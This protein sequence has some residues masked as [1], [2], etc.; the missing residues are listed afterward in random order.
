MDKEILD[1]ITLRLG[2]ITGFLFLAIIIPL[3]I[4]WRKEALN[5]IKS[6]LED[7]IILYKI[8]FPFSVDYVFPFCVGGFF[9]SFILPFWVFNNV[10]NVGIVDKVSLFYFI[11]AELL[12]FFLI[13][14][15]SSWAEVITNKKIRR[16]WN[17]KILNKI[18]KPMD[19]P[20]EEIR[21][22]DLQKFLFLKSISI[23]TKNNLLYTLGG[24]KDMDKIK[25]YLDNLVR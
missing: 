18:G 12:L 25:I 7:E 13:L 8:K 3:R 16:V 20:I 24:Y 4:Y 9:G 10:S 17:L 6:A 14:A 2:I 22:I 19:L 11:P 5:K 15:F 1:Q 23:L 21:S